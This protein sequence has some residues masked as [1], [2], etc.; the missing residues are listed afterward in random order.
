M[1]RIDQRSSLLHVLAQDFTQSGMKKV[2]GS[3]IA[4]GGLADFGVDHRV[5]FH[6]DVDRLFS[7]NFV[8]AHTL[9]RH[10]AAV[11]FRDDK[12][13]LAVIKDTD[14]TNL[15]AGIGVEGRVVEDDLA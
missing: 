12:V 3:V 15:T 11:D 4:H 2:R 6:A 13:P 10:V 7:N 14:V 1:A 5:N 9:Y 8:G